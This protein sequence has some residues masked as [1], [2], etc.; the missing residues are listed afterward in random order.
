MNDHRLYGNP[1]A[2]MTPP[3][4]W[5]EACDREPKCRPVVV[6]DP[7]SREQVER[8]L[9]YYVAPFEDFVTDGRM[10]HMQAALREFASPPKVYRH[11]VNV[12]DGEIATSLCG[13]VWKPGG[14]VVVKSDCPTCLD[15]VDNRWVA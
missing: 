5:T 12:Q 1:A 7:E 6:I 9:S 11:Y 2:P 14:D 10:D 4:Y 13:K 3:H 15:L 8:L